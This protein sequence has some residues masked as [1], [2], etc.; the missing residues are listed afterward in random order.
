MSISAQNHTNRISRQAHASSAISAARRVT[1]H[2]HRT[3]QPVLI[4]GHSLTVGVCAA[5]EWVSLQMANVLN[6]TLRV[7]IVF[8]A[9][10]IV[11]AVVLAAI[12]NSLGT[13]VSAYLVS[14]RMASGSASRVLLSLWAVRSA[15]ELP[16]FPATS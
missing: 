8:P 4:Q 11:L 16:V 10:I 13:V 7:R 1:A 3:A 12:V 9:L 15:I 14:M 6:V 5:K 2:F